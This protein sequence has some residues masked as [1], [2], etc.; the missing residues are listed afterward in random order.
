MSHSENANCLTQS[1][2]GWI[3]LFFIF[4]FKIDESEVKGFDGE[5]WEDHYQAMHVLGEVLG[6]I[7]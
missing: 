3:L 5:G 7:G 4:Q 2:G 6:G 1:E